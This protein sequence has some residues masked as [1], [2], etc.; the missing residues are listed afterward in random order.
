MKH[1]YNIYRELLTVAVK[2]VSRQSPRTMLPNCWALIEANKV[3]AKKNPEGKV[4]I[5]N[6]D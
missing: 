2:S 4:K 1:N 6:Q 3:D 5:S